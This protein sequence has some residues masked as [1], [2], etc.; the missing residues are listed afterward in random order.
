MG[1][2]NRSTREE[3]TS[4]SC[5]DGVEKG[6]LINESGEMGI[7]EVREQ[8]SLISLQHRQTSDTPTL[9][10]STPDLPSIS[11][12]TSSLSQILSPAVM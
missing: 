3:E 6:V 11:P 4:V 10:T 5:R 12:S 8:T 9:T 2:G 1:R 7:S